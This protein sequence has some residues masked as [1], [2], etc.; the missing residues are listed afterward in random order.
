MRQSRSILVL[1]IALVLS[2]PFAVSTEDV[3]DTTYDE[4]ESLPYETTAVFSI[5]A[6]E[7]VTA[8]STE[9]LRA[10]PL[11]G[12][13]FTRLSTRRP[14]SATGAVYSVCDSLTILDHCLRI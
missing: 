14:G 7:T 5:A 6:S 10:L 8:A 2:L 13:G 1:S 12:R 11:R 9:P 4:S 3:P